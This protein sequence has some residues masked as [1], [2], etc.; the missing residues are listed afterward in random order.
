M[1]ERLSAVVVKRRVFV[2]PKVETPVPPS[3]TAKSVIPVIDP[4]VMVTAPETVRAPEMSKATEGFVVPMPTNPDALIVIPEEVAL[5]FPPGVI[6]NL[7]ASE[8]SKPRNHSSV[9]LSWN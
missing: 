1:E 4:D 5:K 8:L 3:A 7:F 9:P 2:P 6:L